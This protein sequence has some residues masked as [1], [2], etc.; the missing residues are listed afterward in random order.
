MERTWNNKAWF[1]VLPVLVL[2]AFSAIWVPSAPVLLHSTLAYPGYAAGLVASCGCLLAAARVMGDALV[3]RS[4]RAEGRLL[5]GKEF[6]RY[7]TR[8][9]GSRAL[10]VVSEYRPRRSAG[11]RT[12]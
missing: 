8:Y 2:V 6:R 7:R 11:R 5:S 3:E 1:M 4:I 12:R 10:G 9:A